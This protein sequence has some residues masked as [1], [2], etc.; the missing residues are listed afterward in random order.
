[1]KADDRTDPMG[2]WGPSKRILLQWDEH[3]VDGTVMKHAN[4]KTYFVWPERDRLYVS[5]MID[6]VTVSGNRILLRAPQYDWECNVLEGPFTIY[7]QNVTYLIFSACFTGGPNYSLGLMSIDGD[8]DPM[9]T[10]EWWYGD[11][12]GPVF[13]RNDEEGVYGTGHASFTTSPDGTETWMVYHA[14]TDPSHFFGFRIARAEK[15][16]WGDDGKPIFPRPHGYFH[17]QPVPSGQLS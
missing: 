7:N 17:P 1:M 14:S 5:Q 13:W 16:T 10:A 12:N 9:N 2:N 15:I 8:K 4:G 6:P 3:C 11:P